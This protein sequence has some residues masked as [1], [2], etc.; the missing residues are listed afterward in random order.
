MLIASLIVATLSGSTLSGAALLP[1]DVKDAQSV[2]STVRAD[3]AQQAQ[4]ALDNAGSDFF[5]VSGSGAAAAAGTED[6]VTVPMG[7]KSYALTDVPQSEWY[8]PYVRDMATRGI[9][10]GYRNSA[11]QPTGIFGPEKPV[12]VE[13]LAKMALAATGADTSSCRDP[14]NATALGSWSVRYIGCAEQRGLTVYSD[15]TV[16]VAR[17]AL[18]GEVAQTILEAFGVTL[19]P[20]TDADK[21]FTDVL[22]STLFASAIT[23]AA[24]D[25][26]VTGYKDANGNMTGLFGPDRRVTR[27]EISKILSLAIQVYGNK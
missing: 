14:V 6:F 25:G 3:E 20:F 15:G 26:I 9:V 2:L 4:D 1:Q 18:R 8:A 16:N 10:S 24:K 13:E 23:R 12:S 17:P 27:A 19:A 11:G 5:P 21:F 7:E 22:P